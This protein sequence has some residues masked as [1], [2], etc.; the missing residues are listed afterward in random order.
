[1]KK[2]EASSRID[3]V[4]IY[5]DRVMVT[6]VAEFEIKEPTEVVFS[7]LPGAIDDQSVRI[8]AK[9]LK[10]GEVLVKP[11]YT[12][13]PLPRTKE[14]EARV[15]KLEI[16][17]RTL[18]DEAVVQ[19]EKEKFLN[20][21]SVIHREVFSK[22]IMGAK[23]SPDSWREGLRFVSEELAKLKE[24]ILGIEMERR[25]LKKKLDALK[26]ELQDIQSY[27]K[28]RKSIVFDVHPDKGGRY[29]IELRYILYGANW[30]TY[31]ELRARPSQST[32]D[33]SYYSK[34]S[35]RTGEDW[36]DVQ[37]ILSTSKPAYGGAPPEPHPWYI[38]LYTPGPERRARAEVLDAAAPSEVFDEEHAKAP[39]PVESG[40]SIIYP[41]PGRHTVKS[42][43]PEHKLRIVDVHI[44]AD[45][46]YFIIPRHSEF[47]YLTGKFRNDTDYLFLEGEAGTYV[48]DD[49]T[50]N[51]YLPPIAPDQEQTL[52]FGIDERVKV[53]RELEKSKVSKGGLVK[54]NTKYEFIYE[55]KIE[56]F[57]KKEIVCEIVDFVPVSQNPNV[58]VDDVKFEPNPTDD[59]EKE[60]GIYRW[61]TSIPPG[62]EYTIK[63]F[64][65]VEAP[66]EGEVEGL[67]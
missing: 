3:S 8:K 31:Y 24:R 10:V 20:S 38:D 65:T 52:S 4:V 55:N 37:L 54:K 50:G 15:K 61:E 53:K 11:G 63:V 36:N 5:P 30:K 14:L 2:V 35:Q 34:V 33:L 16:K 51:Y 27:S 7:D 60:M 47:A 42:G 41:L 64:F 56:N 48:G 45:F 26:A 43:E 66:M 59:K 1:M 9:N 67:M 28:N 39:T 19:Q 22:E 62:K 25:E 44:K 6:R 23:I 18:S 13:I 57:H 12:K 58:K 40:I 32:I 17:D 21:L 49:F 46:K 29:M